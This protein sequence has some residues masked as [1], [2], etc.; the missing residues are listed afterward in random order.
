MTFERKNIRDMEGYTPGEQPKSTD[1]VKLNTNENPFAPGPAVQK[2]LSEIKTDDLRCYPQPTA[3]ELRKAISA[4]HDIETESIIVTNGGDELLRLAIS[5]F[6]E[7]DEAI[8]V[9]EPTYTLYEV[10]AQAHGC[11]YLR[12]KL[13]DDWSLPENFAQTLNNANAKMCLLP[14]PHAPSGTLLPVEELAALANEFI[15]IL[16]IDEAYIDFVDPSLNHDCIKLINDFDNVLLLRTF[17]KGYSLAGLR[18]AYGIGP[19]SL[20]YPMQSKTK[21]SYNTDFIA[22]K[23]A[24]AALEDQAY[25]KKAWD[26]VRA[27][28]AMLK[29]ALAELGLTSV[30]SQSNFLLVSVPEPIKA[31]ELYK[32]LKQ[33]GILVRHFNHAG[34]ENYLRM[35]VGNTNENQLLLSTLKQLLAE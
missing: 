5:T 16:L 33:H 25:A 31:E 6:V 1:I 23:L 17:S 11:N 15:G 34:Q 22:Q 2:A 26:F 10:L 9:A 35:T 20:I 32:S 7:T 14:N 4:H 24:Q 8:A 28:R 29:D 18:I 12:F 19:S 27:Q 3:L 21:D 13:N 30:E